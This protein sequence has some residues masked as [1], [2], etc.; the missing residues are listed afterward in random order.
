MKANRGQ[1]KAKAIYA[2]QGDRPNDLSFRVGD[3]ID[4]ISESSASGPDWWEGELN[5]RRGPFP[6]N[7]VEILTG[8]HGS[9]TPIT[10]S[11]SGLME[12]KIGKPKRPE[13]FQYDHIAWKVA[14]ITSALATIMM[15]VSLIMPW[16]FIVTPNV[17]IREFEFTGAKN[18]QS[19]SLS[20]PRAVLTTEGDGYS[21]Y[22]SLGWPQTKRL[23][24]ITVVLMV[25][26]FVIQFVITLLVFI[27]TR[28]LL[29]KVWYLPILG[30]LSFLFVL[31]APVNYAVSINADIAKEVIIPTSG[32]NDSLGGP[33]VS[34]QGTRTL[35]TTDVGGGVILGLNGV[36][37]WGP[38]VAWFFALI[39]I[40][41]SF[42]CYFTLFLIVLGRRV[43]CC[44]T[45]LRG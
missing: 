19:N 41:P 6:L 23:H 25:A 24:Q 38:T 45:K 2:Y 22:D 33:R 21:S 32:D 7:H 9:S 14:L 35:T 13:L 8:S 17:F 30:L 12:P 4:V 42:I 1:K 10:A 28:E 44:G 5:G 27:R 40:F 37:T 43:I 16:Y 20:N 18:Y 34:F 15:L 11:T 26:A 3:I 29:K 31:I 36:Q 39:A